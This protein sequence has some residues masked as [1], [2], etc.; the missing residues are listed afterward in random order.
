[1]ADDGLLYLVGMAGRTSEEL[2]EAMEL[3]K[4]IERAKGTGRLAEGAHRWP[5]CETDPA[6]TDKTA[7][8]ARSEAKAPDCQ[9]QG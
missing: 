4:F 1:V 5:R 7:A 2:R 9:R 6:D 3:F 8:P